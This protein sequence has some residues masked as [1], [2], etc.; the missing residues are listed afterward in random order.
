[1][2]CCSDL[3]AQAKYILEETL[4]EELYHCQMLRGSGGAWG[5]LHRAF[6]HPWRLFATETGAVVTGWLV[7]CRL[8]ASGLLGYKVLLHDSFLL[9]ERSSSLA[10]PAQAT[11]AALVAC[12]SHARSSRAGSSC[13]SY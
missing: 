2:L 4:W 12:F 11:P 3:K 10:W 6:P 7:G 1:M 5:L 8:V 9:A 13:C